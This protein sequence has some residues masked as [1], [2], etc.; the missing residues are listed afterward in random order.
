MSLNRW[1]DRNPITSEIK[2][3][4]GRSSSENHIRNGSVKI[5]SHLIGGANTTS[6]Y[7]LA[8]EACAVPNYHFNVRP[9][10]LTF[11]PMVKLEVSQDPVTPPPPSS[12]IAINTPTALGQ[13]QGPITRAMSAKGANSG[14]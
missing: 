1:I 2:F 13:Y 12:R 9:V 6:N 10:S 11:A 4:H 14:E 3:L 5:N 7:H 8:G